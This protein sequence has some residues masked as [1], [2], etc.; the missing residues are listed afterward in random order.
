MYICSRCDLTIC[1][2]LPIS[3]KMMSS[4]QLHR[5]AIMLLFAVTLRQNQLVVGEPTC[6]PL[7]RLT[8]AEL[9]ALRSST[10]SSFRRLPKLLTRLWCENNNSVPAEGNYV[11]VTFPQTMVIYGFVTRGEYNVWRGETYDAYVKKFTL[12]CYSDKA[13]NLP[14]SSVNTVK[15]SSVY[16]R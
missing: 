13:I 1:C 15:W 3:C 9:S 7:R 4:N 2:R 8:T 10:S 5:F 12:T 16:Y 14:V 6:L 11:N